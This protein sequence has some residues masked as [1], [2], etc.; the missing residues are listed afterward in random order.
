MLPPSM[1]CVV[2]CIRT[3]QLFDYCNCVM[4][5]VCAVS[6]SVCHFTILVNNVFINVYIITITI[7]LIIIIIPVLLCVVRACLSAA[8]ALFC[9][10]HDAWWYAAT[11]AALVPFHPQYFSS[12]LS[13]YNTESST[14]SGVARGPTPNYSKGFLNDTV[15]H[16]TVLHKKR[17]TYICS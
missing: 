3:L 9:Q 13:P 17:T 16:H 8:D 7:V 15:G 11:D 14:I 6:L 10:L 5:V 2:L 1:R 12:Y 4:Y